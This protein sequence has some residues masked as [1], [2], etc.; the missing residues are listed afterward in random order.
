MSNRFLIDS[1][2]A[3]GAFSTF[4]YDAGSDMYLLN[5]GQRFD[6]IAEANKREFN[7]DKRRH[8]DGLGRKVAS[9]PLHLFFQ[10]QK[11]GITRDRKA[12]ARW[13]NDSDNRVFRTD[14]S[15]V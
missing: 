14:H 13:L 11:Q 8:G 9:I 15:A 3:T 6:A 1:D 2:A 4:E 10:M 5:Q 12:M 7:E